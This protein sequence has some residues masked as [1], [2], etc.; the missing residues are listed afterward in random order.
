MKAIQDSA[1]FLF[2]LA[3]AVLTFVCMLGV[4]EVF[5]TDVIWKSFQTVGLLAMVAAIVVFAGRFL[6]MSSSSVVS[7][8]NPAFTSLR[9]ITL[10][11]LI[12]AS[13]L[14]AF[15][16]VLGIWDV[17]ADTDVLYK[18]IGSLAILAF[19][20]FIMV[21]ICMDRENNPMLKQQGVS[22]GGAVAAL[23]FLYLIFAFSGFFSS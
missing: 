15:I 13:S 11:V 23:V 6:G 18:A 1:A 5:D 12:I 19:G 17:I 22:F 2:V 10:G 8:P 21:V 14:L 7:L 3:V 9:R 16:G 4:W 20:S